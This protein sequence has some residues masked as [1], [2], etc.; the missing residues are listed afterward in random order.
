MRYRAVIYAES[1]ARAAAFS[2]RLVG[3]IHYALGDLYVAVYCW[4]FPGVACGRTLTLTRHYGD[5]DGWIMSL[6]L[7]MDRYWFG[8]ETGGSRL[9][10]LANSSGLARQRPLLLTHY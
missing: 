6:G 5:N 9:A 2:S 4:S 1:Y 7:R 10:T 3:G 8:I